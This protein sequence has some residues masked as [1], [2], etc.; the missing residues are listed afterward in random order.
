MTYSNVNK[1]YGNW[2]ACYSC[3]FDIEDGHTLMTCLR[4]WRKLTHIEAFTLRNAQSYIVA[5]YDCCTRGMHKT[6]LP[7]AAF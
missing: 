5:G 4:D 1:V 2:N 6:V 3:G 7:K